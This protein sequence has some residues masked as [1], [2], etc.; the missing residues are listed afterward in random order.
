MAILGWGVTTGVVSDLRAF[1]A[2][3]KFPAVP[4]TIKYFGDSSTPDTSGDGATGEWE[5]DT[6]ASTGMAPN[7]ASET[8]YFAHHNSDERRA[9]GARGLGERQAWPAAGE[10]FVR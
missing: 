3:N 8:L 4:V 9:R 1:E 10:R 2:E 7:V 5:P 6:Q